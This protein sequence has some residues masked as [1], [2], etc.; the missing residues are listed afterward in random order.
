MKGKIGINLLVLILL[1]VTF[2]FIIDQNG[3]DQTYLLPNGFEGCVMINYDVEGAPPLKIEDN[4]IV[5]KVPE[6]G[7]IN[8]SSSYDF[9]WT[10]EEHSGSFQLSAFYVG[11]DGKTLEELPQKKI[12][13]GGT[14][15][16]QKEK[17]PMTHHYYQIFG[18]KEMEDKGCSALD[19]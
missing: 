4:E 12:R 16:V 18:S 15:S 2:K 17:Q 7:I 3:V 6:S 1:G 10:N 9:G 5:Y 11:D 19:F 8:T 14:E 13:F